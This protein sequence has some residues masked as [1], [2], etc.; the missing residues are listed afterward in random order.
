MKRFYEKEISE[1]TENKLDF[2]IQGMR[3]QNQTLI[4]KVLE[5]KFDFNQLDFVYE[6]EITHLYKIARPQK[7]VIENAELAIVFCCK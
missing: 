2:I 3:N 6:A 4:R 1:E 7:E 5:Y